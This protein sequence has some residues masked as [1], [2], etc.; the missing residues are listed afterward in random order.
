MIIEQ[1][2]TDEVI[3]V[4]FPY[5]KEIG[6]AIITA[7]VV[8]VTV[9]EGTDATPAAILSGVAQISGSEIRQLV[10]NGVAG[11]KYKLHCLA[12]FDDGKKLAREY[13]VEVLPT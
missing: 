3:P 12:T 9:L 2:S 8:T 4:T 7:R 5:A 1:K 6:A 13:G 11:V 10:Q